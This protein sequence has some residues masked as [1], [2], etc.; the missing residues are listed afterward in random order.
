MGTVSETT[1]VSTGMQKFTGGFRKLLAWQKAHELTILIYKVT[2][3]FPP[4]E[5]F[6]IVDQLRRASSSIGAQIAE[7]SRMNSSPHRRIY[8]ERA[9][10]SHAEVDNFLELAHDLNLIADEQYRELL[11]KVNKAGYFVQKLLQSCRT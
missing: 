2:T 5:R 4:S 8:Y 3:M 7:G 1:N 10:A 9:Y 11:E 6:G